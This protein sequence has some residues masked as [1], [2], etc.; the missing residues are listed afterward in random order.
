MPVLPR[1]RSR[2]DGVGADGKLGG[3][4]GVGAAAGDQRDQFPFPGVE[5]LQARRGGRFARRFCG[6]QQRA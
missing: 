2:S 3:D 1:I 5:L 4:L 6:G